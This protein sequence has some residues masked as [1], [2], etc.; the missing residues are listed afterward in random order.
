MRKIIAKTVSVAL[1][2]AM[3]ATVASCG[4][5]KKAGKE[6]RKISED[7]PWFDASITD[8]ETGAEKGRETGTWLYQQFVASDDQYY[9]IETSGEYQLPPD[10]MIDVK[11]LNYRDYQFDYIA[12][13]DRNTKQT[14]NTIDLKKDLTASEPFTDNIFQTTAR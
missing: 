14:V 8:V 4:E 2:C 13:V 10:N 6:I 1:V 3:A 7:S 5:T 11:T 12:V 9:F